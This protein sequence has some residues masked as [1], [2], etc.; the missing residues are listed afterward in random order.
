VVKPPQRPELYFFALQATF[1][2]GDRH[3]GGAHLGLQ[4]NRRHPGNTAVNWGGYRS[5]D[6]GGQI[7]E[8]T[9]S[10]LPSQPDDPNT[11]DYP[12]RPGRRYRLTI[13]P[14]STTGW[15]AGTIEDLSSGAAP[16][17][18][19]ELHG[20]GS[21]LAG[22]LV[23]AEVFAR[24]DDPGVMIHWSSLEMARAPDAWAPITIVEANYQAFSAG[25]CTNTTSAAAG[26]GGFV[27]ITNSHRVNPQGAVLH[28]RS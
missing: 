18:V 28:S 10:S 27:Q 21:T 26:D 25:G 4:W 19:R 24:C 1:A 11:R 8:G 23:W 6:L 9:A 22:P 17:L 12:W 16:L 14:G 20:G 13:R 2:E 5:Q 3:V 15:W 7:L